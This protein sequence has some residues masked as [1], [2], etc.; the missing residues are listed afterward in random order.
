VSEI[1]GE[2]VKGEDVKGEDSSTSEGPS[3]PRFLLKSV[4]IREDPKSQLEHAFRGKRLD[5]PGQE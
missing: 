3:F 2:D 4:L 1:K 5:I